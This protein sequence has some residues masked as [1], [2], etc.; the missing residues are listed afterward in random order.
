MTERQLAVLEDLAVAHE[1]SA[2]AWI[3]EPQNI[4]RHRVC[5]RAIRAAIRELRKKARPT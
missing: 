1:T 3:T 4:K 5:A 2:A